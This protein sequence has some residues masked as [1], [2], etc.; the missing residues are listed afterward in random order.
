MFP[1]GNPVSLAVKA[2]RQF[3]FETMR[4]MAKKV[5]A[6]ADAKRKDWKDF[7][8]FYFLANWTGVAAA[9][10]SLVG[11]RE[12]RVRANKR[13]M[14]YVHSKLM[15]IDD[16]FV[17]LGSANLNERSLAGDRDAEICVALFA[18]DGKVE[19][20][21]KIIE[22]LRTDA[23][24]RHLGADNV[25]KQAPETVACATI[26]RTAGIENWGSMSGTSRL[27]GQGHLIN[28]PFDA[29]ATTFKL[30]PVSVPGAL[31]AQDAFIFDAKSKAA[32]PAENGSTSDSEWLWESPTNP[33]FVFTRKS[34]A[35]NIAE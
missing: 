23:W 9:G 1:E 3:Q 7:L 17:I 29:T 33:K 30:R 10:R 11:K 15:I 5:F 4:F 21:K 28:L 32:G 35:S 24:A 31:A 6:A 8:S 16:E 34:P 27:P 26:L 19:D 13:Y 18:D 25:P 2:Q 12:E 22:K 14:V 20:C